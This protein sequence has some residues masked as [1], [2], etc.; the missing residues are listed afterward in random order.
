MDS[1]LRRYIRDLLRCSDLVQL[2][3]TLR[4][5]ACER[6][7]LEERSLLSSVYAPR[8]SRMLRSVEPEE[9][10]H[11]SEELAALC[12]SPTGGRHADRAV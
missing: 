10:K 11:L 4:V 6:W 5:F 8:A 1:R 3:A 7:T 12:W 2:H 9:A